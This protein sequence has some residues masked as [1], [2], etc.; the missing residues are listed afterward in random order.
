MSGI[1]VLLSLGIAAHCGGQTPVMRRL[2]P[3]ETTA[4]GHSHI[5]RIPPVVQV[6]V[7]EAISPKEIDDAYL[8]NTAD[9]QD[10]SQESNAGLNVLPAPQSL[11]PEME[12]MFD[13]YLIQTGDELEVK[14]R[15]TPELNEIVTVRPDGMIS[16]QVVGA[17]LA[18]NRT[19]RELH[20]ELV[21]AFTPALKNPAIVVHV[22][23]FA[24]NHV[25]VGGEVA[26]PSRIPITGQLSVLQAVI[27]AGGFKDT[28]DERR[29]ILRREGG[30][31]V[32]LNLKADIKGRVIGED[33]LLRPYDVIYVPKSRIAKVN[34][35]VDQYIEKLLPFQRS[36]GIFITREM[37]N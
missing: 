15:F 10:L 33:V 26:T 19:P 12:F 7:H 23:R 1:F 9:A 28:A 5:H 21:A 11:F 4:P 13:E 2:P 8:P 29:I 34:L 30:Y 20:A 31:S 22:R 14:F 27:R 32:A 6:A 18:A 35:F 24:A 17:I 37:G 16:L 36:T 25:F 3:C